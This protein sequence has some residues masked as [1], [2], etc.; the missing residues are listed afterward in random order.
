[1]GSRRMFS[2]KIINTAKFLKLPIEAQNLYFHMGLRA[3]D[4]E[5]VTVGEGVIV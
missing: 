2:L 3:D 5:D 4:C 1:M